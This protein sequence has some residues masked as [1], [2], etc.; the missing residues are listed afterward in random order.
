MTI[1]QRIHR[2]ERGG[3]GILLLMTVLALAA[4]MGLA[5]NTAENSIRRRH[6]QMAADATA[7]ASAMWMS[8]GT[9]I[10]SATNMLICQNSSAEVIWRAARD[11]GPIVKNRLD[12]EVV[13]VPR[14][15]ARIQQR[16]DANRRAATPD[17]YLEITLSIEESVLLEIVRRIPPQYVYYDQLIAQIAPALAAMDESEF[18][19][20]RDEVFEYQTRVVDAVPAAV[21]D[22][23]ASMGA[24]Y[25]VT[26]AMATPGAQS[27]DGQTVDIPLPVKVVTD[28][29]VEGVVGRAVQV[30]DFDPNGNPR[31]YTVHGG[32]WGEILCPPLNRYFHNR[33]SRDMGSTPIRPIL[34]SLDDLRGPG[35]VDWD[36]LDLLPPGDTILHLI[37]DATRFSAPP[38]MTEDEIVALWTAYD[39]A[40]RELLRMGFHSRFALPSFD[41]RVDHYRRIILT[42]MGVDPQW[43]FISYDRYYIP[44]WARPGVFQDAYDNVYRSVYNSNYGRLWRGR[45]EYYRRLWRLRIF[46]NPTLDAE[47]R[48]LATEF[49]RRVATQG[50]QRI[51]ADVAPRWIARTWP[52][53]I[54]PPETP[55]P[56]IP[57]LTDEVRWRHLTLLAAVQGTEDQHPKHFLPK[58]FTPPETAYVAWA[59]AESYNFHEFSDG[60]GGGDRYDQWM[61]PRPWRVSTRGGWSWQPRL[62]FSDALGDAMYNSDEFR[63]MLSETGVSG[64]DDAALRELITH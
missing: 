4:L 28:C 16:R 35:D 49:A 6:V 29:N 2:D 48:R 31:D 12:G 33:L 53:E 13:R 26:T 23:R 51:A 54:V 46:P 27:Y 55:V 22:E 25:K 57:G 42:Q 19:V 60:Y 45:Y 10:I 7:H 41:S 63:A 39:R 56:P 20:R 61:P 40:R 8:R 9:N 1:L 43:A 21:R 44:D 32:Y 30:A 59:Q 50:A 52:Y 36:E 11:I 38:G 24:Q 62:A 3:I 17:P 14:E 58:L 64:N 15:L 47:A 18:R 5:W 34:R 37:V